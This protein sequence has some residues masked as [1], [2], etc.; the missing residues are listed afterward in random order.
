MI[1]KEVFLC[2]ILI[3]IATV[4]VTLVNSHVDEEEDYRNECE[5][6]KIRY[7]SDSDIVFMN[8]SILV[9]NDMMVYR[10]SIKDEI[11]GNTIIEAKNGKAGS[12]SKAH[13]FIIKEHGRSR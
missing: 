10:H 11:K 9:T 8:D 3:A 6:R 4:F 12:T 1:N 2:L 7:Y 13:G 5:D